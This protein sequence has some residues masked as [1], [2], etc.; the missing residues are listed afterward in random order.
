MTTASDQVPIQIGTATQVPVTSGLVLLLQSDIKIGL[1]AGN[2]VTAWLDGSGQGNNLFAQGNPQLVENQTPT[3]QSAIVFD[4]TGDLLQRVNATD[5]IFNLPTGSANR[6]IFVVV[7][8]VNPEGVSA[9]VVYGDGASNETFGVVADKNGNL[10]VQGYGSANDFS[11]GQNGVTGGFMVQSVVLK[12][13]VTFHYKN[14]AQ[15][16]SDPHAFNTDLKKLVLGAEI[17]GKGEAQLKLG[18][19]LIY[20]RAVTETERLQIE[21][22]LKTKYITGPAVPVPPVAADDTAS[23]VAGT[24]VSIDVLA[25]D[26]DGNNDPLTITAVSTPAHGTA[27][28]NKNGT[29]ANPADDRIVYT[30][31]AG[32]TGTD[33]FTYTISDGHGGI[34]TATA[35]VSVTPPSAGVPVTAGLVGAYEAGE[36]VGLGTGNAVHSWLDGS[37]FGNDLTAA[38]NPALLAAAT[39]A[40]QSAIVFDGAGDLLQRVNATD[41]LNGLAAGGAN[42]TI[43][44]VVDYVNPE[45]VSAGVVYGDGASNEAFGLVANSGGNLAVQ[46]WG[47]GNDFSSGQNGVTGGFMVQ[48]VVLE[49][50]RTFHYKN[51]AQIDTDPHTFNTD[52]KK[53]VLGA[54]IKGLGELQMAIGAVLIYNRALNATERGQVE[55]YLQS[56]YLTGTAPDNGRRLPSTIPS[57]S[58]RTP[59][60]PAMCSP[61][62]AVPRTTTRA[63][64]RWR[65]TLASDVTHGTLTLN[66]N[67]SFSYTPDPDFAG[68]DSFIYQLSDG[69]GGID[70]RDRHPDRDPGQ[71]SRPGVQRQLRHHGGHDPHGLR[72][73]RC[74]GERHR[75]G[76]RS[77]HRRAPDRRLERHGRARGE[78][79][80]HLQPERGLRRD[81]QLRLSGDRRRQCDRHDQRGPADPAD[82]AG[83][84]VRDRRERH[85]RDGRRRHRLDGRLGQGQSSHGGRESRPCMPTPRPRAPTPSP[86]TGPATC[87]SGSM[88]PRRCRA[89]PRAARIGRSSSSS[90]MSIPRGFPPASSTGT[91]PRTRPSGWWPTRTATSRSRATAAPTTSSRAPTGSPAASWCSRWC[92][93]IT[94]SRTTLMVC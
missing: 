65:S 4:G 58:S 67:G 91:V 32:F 41:S 54:E 25:N 60:S 69:K 5:T 42:R 2:T 40:G 15:I 47:S 63:A 48:S 81:R 94:S 50:N 86:S 85:A 59:R 64:T 89:C 1:G 29:P 11:A 57:S 21:D 66:A 24:T 62:T 18:A 30:P 19:V 79:Q 75:P 9:G 77:L 28:I 74:A 17:A 34:D 45:G 61:P 56:K 14:G 70:T 12:N 20:D 23:T 22:F 52:L 93:T 73:E 13:N 88:P 44:M 49:N 10:G 68:S 46:G 35:T 31:N 80:L 33:S 78:R 92:S 7:D 72:R 71:R 84:A 51:G 39:P 53:L 38:G 16:D 87:C 6:T 27:V 55:A 36:N 3:G 76:G 83:G 37:G 82:G 43:F 90:T 8:Y 26:S